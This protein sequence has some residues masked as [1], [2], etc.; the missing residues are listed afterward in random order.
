MLGEMTRT[1]GEVV[2]RGKIA[3]FAQQSWV[4]SATVKD[5]ITCVRFTRPPRARTDLTPAASA[6]RSTPS[7]TSASSRLVPYSRIFAFFPRET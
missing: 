1:Q 3:Y 2:I 4:L 7:S 5:N 6:I